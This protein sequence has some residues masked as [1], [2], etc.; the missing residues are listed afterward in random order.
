[1][2][3]K[4]TTIA[5]LVWNVD[6]KTH[7]QP[8]SDR[9]C[10]AGWR[11]ERKVRGRKKGSRKTT[12][13]EDK[14]IKQSFQKAR[15]PLGSLVTS[16]DVAEELPQGLRGKVS[17][18]TIRRRLAELGYTP[19]RK[20]EKQDFLNKQRAVRISFCKSHAHRTP[21]MWAAHLQSEAV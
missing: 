15:L 16:R 7:P 11:R 14:A 4:W 18:R 20:S 8:C 13:A 5:S 6:G 19:T 1:M 10:V 17:R 21:A 2:P 12:T 3:L 9:K